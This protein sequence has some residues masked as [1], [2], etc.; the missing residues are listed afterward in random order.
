MNQGLNDLTSSVQVLTLNKGLHLITVAAAAPQRLGDDGELML[1]AIHVG[2]GPGVVAGQVEIMPGPRN[3]GCWL[4]E[5]RDM[6]V[7]RVAAPQA[8][9]MLTT[10]RA[11]P[12]PAIQVEVTRLDRRTAAASPAL[13]ALTAPRP[14]EVLAPPP[15]PSPPSTPMHVGA[16]TPPALK[17]AS[18]RT[19]LSTRLDLHIQNRG[20]VA[21]V[22]NFWAGALG[23]RLAIEAMAISPLE[24][25]APDQIEYAGVG[26]NGVETGWVEGGRLCGSRGRGAALAG[27]AVRLKPG[28]DMAYDCEYRGSFRSGRIVGPMRGGAPCRSDPGDLLEAIQLFITPRSAENTAGPATEEASPSPRRIGPRFSVFRELVE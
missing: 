5:A 7:V 1:P 25:L 6:L 13:A 2:V 16:P 11:A 9:L 12:L 23:E 4:F 10:V 3:S 17:T 15:A 24:G 28:A 18:G 14:P 20:D 21:Y 19:A 27:F 8:I 26:E 22:N